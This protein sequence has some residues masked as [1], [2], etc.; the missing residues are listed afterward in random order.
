ME[1]TIEQ[2]SVDKKCFDIQ[3]K[4]LSLD[5]DRLLDHIICQD[6]INIVMHADYVP[7]NV[8][9][10]YNECLVHDKLEIEQLEQETDHLYV[11]L[12]SQEI[13]HIVMTNKKVIELDAEFI[14]YKGE[15][16]ASMDALEKKIDDGI[17]KVMRRVFKANEGRIR[18]WQVAV[19]MAPYVPPIRYVMM[20]LGWNCI[21]LM[22][23]QA[24][25]WEKNLRPKY[26]DVE[27]FYKL[28]IAAIKEEKNQE[29]EGQVPSFRVQLNQRGHKSRMKA[30]LFWKKFCVGNV[31]HPRKPRK[32]LPRHSAW[33]GFGNFGFT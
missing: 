2:C 9:P 18:W 5:N 4:E 20:I 30:R 28:I 8:L 16:K 26:W 22:L 1:A 32:H 25:L 19:K 29:E 27:K 13:V 10:A 23:N 21:I 15:A 7:V 24:L 12:L 6:V 33:Y 3:K 17:E 14:K 11:L 31:P